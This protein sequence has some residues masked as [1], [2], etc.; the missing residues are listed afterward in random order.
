MPAA[1]A[2]LLLPS[3]SP[4]SSSCSCC[5]RLALALRL[6]SCRLLKLLLPPLLLL[7][8]DSSLLNQDLAGIDDDGLRGGARGWGAAAT[9]FGRNSGPVHT[10]TSGAEKFDFEADDDDTG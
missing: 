4:W 5:V 2:P 1:T 7:L 10:N 8:L 3:S 9:I 6:V